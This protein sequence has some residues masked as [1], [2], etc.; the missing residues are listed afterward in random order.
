ML[1]VFFFKQKTAYEMR[2][3]GWS[4]DVCSSDL[5]TGGSASLSV[6]DGGL[7]QTASLLVSANGAGGIG[8]DGIGAGTG[9]SASIDVIGTGSTVQAMSVNV[10]ATGTGASLSAASG[11]D[12]AGGTAAITVQDGAALNASNFVGVDARSEEHTSELP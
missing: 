2:I 7:V 1:F 5:A 11:G 8:S 9:G 3:S 12:G 10:Q 6:T 4:S